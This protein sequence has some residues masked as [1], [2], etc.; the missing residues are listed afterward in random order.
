[1]DPTTSRLGDWCW[2]DMTRGQWGLRMRCACGHR[3]RRRTSSS[4]KSCPSRRGPSTVISPPEVRAHGLWMV[5]S[6]LGC[7]PSY[8]YRVR[9]KRQDAFP[10]IQGIYPGRSIILQ[11]DILISISSPPT[12]PRS[13]ISHLQPPPIHNEAPPR[14]HQPARPHLRADPHPT[15]HGEG[16]PV[17]ECGNLDVMTVDPADLPAGVAPRDVRKCLDHPLGRNR[18]VKGASLAPLDAVDVSFWNNS[19]VDAGAGANTSPVE[20][21]STAST[22]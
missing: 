22:P 10:S 20:A 1:M 4:P 8:H 11:Q 12:C 17:V 2:L 5:V 16:D 7:R 3:P 13:H 6:P 15:R 18:H 9:Y 19:T 21:R 14:P